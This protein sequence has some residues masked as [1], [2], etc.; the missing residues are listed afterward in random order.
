MKL[1]ELLL[2]L[3]NEKTAQNYLIEEGVFAKSKKCRLCRKNMKIQKNQSRYKCKKCNRTESIFKKTFFENAKIQLDSLLLFSY[4]YLIKTPVSGLIEATGHSSA[5]ISEWSKFIRQLCGESVNEN[6]LKIGGQNIIVE[7]DETKLGKRKYHR[8]HKVDGVWIVAGVERTTEKRFF[9]V[10]VESRDTSTITNILR[11]FVLPG[12]IVYTDCWKAYK[13]STEFLSLVHCTVNHSKYFKDP[14]TGV[15]TNTIEGCNN[16]LKTL[17]KP[18]NRV[19][20]GI[21]SYLM[22][23]VW[24]RQNKKNIWNGFI[25]ALKNIKYL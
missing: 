5:T 17:I 19:K 4:L 7:I 15:H 23:Y 24:R 22:Y 14:I 16:G 8:G 25:D 6:S 9:A 2:H 13:P 11:K 1:K 10:E 20:K 18:R 12:S 3:T 21:R